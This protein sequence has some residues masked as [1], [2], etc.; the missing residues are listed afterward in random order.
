MKVLLCD[1]VRNVFCSGSYFVQLDVL[2]LMGCPLGKG[3]SCTQSHHSANEVASF[4]RSFL[5]E[6]E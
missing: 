4:A 1:H 2:L 6:E 3:E 5:R